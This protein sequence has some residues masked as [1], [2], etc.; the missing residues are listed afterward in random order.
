MTKK[1]VGFWQTVGIDADLI[2]TI[3][4]AD[5][6]W[7]GHS[8]CVSSA[9]QS[10]P[11]AIGHVHKI[12]LR[13]L[14]IRKF[15][16][17]RWLREGTACRTLTAGGPRDGFEAGRRYAVACLHLGD[18]GVRGRVSDCPHAGGRQACAHDRPTEGGCAGRV[19]LHRCDKIGSMERPTCKVIVSNARKAHGS[20]GHRWPLR[21][22]H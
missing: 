13:V 21:E 7:D 18:C 3:A 8:L 11:D 4:E 5:P 6:H 16:G 19:R 9:I 1:Y 17:T 22:D 15:T 20:H 12:F 14:K 10:M 2:E